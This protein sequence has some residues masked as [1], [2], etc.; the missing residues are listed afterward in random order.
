MAMKKL[1]IRKKIS[2]S[3]CRENNVSAQS[4]ATFSLNKELN[5]VLHLKIL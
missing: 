5:F 4:G 2:Y 1:L 3:I